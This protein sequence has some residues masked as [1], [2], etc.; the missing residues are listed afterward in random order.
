[1]HPAESFANLMLGNDASLPDVQ[2]SMDFHL[3]D[4][5]RKQLVIPLR[6][7]K[8]F[9][10]AQGD[11]IFFAS[12]GNLKNVAHGMLFIRNSAKGYNHLMSISIP[13]D[14]ITSQRPVV[15]A[16]VYLFIP[17]IDKS[18]L[19]GNVPTKKSGAKIN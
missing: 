2:L 4:Y 5:H 18:H 19:F 17:T 8:C 15:N 6:Q 12:S 1:M 13:L 9:S 3:S 11:Q 7:L 16:A 14:D 10:E